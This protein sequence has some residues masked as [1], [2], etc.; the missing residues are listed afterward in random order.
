M[1]GQP[2]DFCRHV[3]SIP[4][5]T[6][7]FDFDEVDS[8]VENLNTSSRCLR[9]CYATHKPRGN[10]LQNLTLV[11]VNLSVFL[12]LSPV[13]CLTRE[14]VMLREKRPR[15][16]TK[17]VNLRPISIVS[18]HAAIADGVTAMRIRPTMQRYCGETQFGGQYEAFF[19]VVAVVILCQMHK[20]RGLRTYLPFGD[21]LAAFDGAAKDAMLHGIHKAGVGGKCWM[22][23]DD[24]FTHDEC[25]LPMARAKS[26]CFHLE[27]G[28]AQG[29]RLSVDG[30][31]WLMKELHDIITSVSAGVA[32]CATMW[33]K[34]VRFGKQAPGYFSVFIL[35]RCF[36][37]FL[38]SFLNAP[39]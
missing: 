9:L 18:D 37:F 19:C 38:F 36:V 27:K 21:L 14:I 22:L 13:T 12:Q 23:L 8:V 3:S 32:C 5:N 30:F 34:D 2:I 15:V 1:G 26:N 20:E 35:C 33:S 39:E 25:Y 29:R 6:D 11:I 28:T 4:V 16:V 31:N 7:E 17:I 24:I 10:G